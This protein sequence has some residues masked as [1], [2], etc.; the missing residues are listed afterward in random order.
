M[1]TLFY[2]TL[3]PFIAF[4]ALFGFVLYPLRSVLHPMSLVVPTNGLQ[5]PINLLRHWTY[6][7]YYIISDV[8]GSAG[9]PLLFWS[10]ANDVVPLQQVITSTAATTTSITPA[11]I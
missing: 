2:A 9:I 7:L 4:Y 8:W 3:A 1:Q 6:A 5:Y 10:C 11:V